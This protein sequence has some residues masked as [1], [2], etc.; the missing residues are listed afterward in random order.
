M[1]LPHR[2]PQRL[3]NYN[4]TQN[5][6]YFVTICTQDRLNLFGQIENGN[7][8]LNNAGKMVFHKFGE[9]PKVYPD[10]SID[11]FIVMPNHLHAILVI[12]HG[13][14]QQEDSGTPQGAFPTMSLSDYVQRFKTL[15]TRIYIDEV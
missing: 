1:E 3:R 6:M 12:Q 5:G 7:L 2:K 4:Y 11:K 10:I 14:V 8:I 15:T 13:T 9:M